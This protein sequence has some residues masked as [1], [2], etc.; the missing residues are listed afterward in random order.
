MRQ[1]LP[2]V[3][4]ASGGRCFEQRDLGA[5]SGKLLVAAVLP[6]PEIV[7]EAEEQQRES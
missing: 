7:A 2:V 4:A 5:Q 6:G 1:P 3:P